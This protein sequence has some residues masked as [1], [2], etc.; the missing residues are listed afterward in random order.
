M[1]NIISYLIDEG[2]KNYTVTDTHKHVAGIFTR[3]C[4]LSD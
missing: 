4:K 2:V 3:Q 1:E